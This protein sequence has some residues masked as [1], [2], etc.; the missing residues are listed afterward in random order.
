MVVA[1]TMAL[2]IYTRCHFGI[3]MPLSALTTVDPYANSYLDE[4]PYGYSGNNPVYYNDPSGGS[5][6]D[7]SRDD[8]FVNGGYRVLNSLGTRGSNLQWKHSFGG[9]IGL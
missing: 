6:A 2:P 5:Y 1:S 3:M 9:G 8:E 4:S 7:L